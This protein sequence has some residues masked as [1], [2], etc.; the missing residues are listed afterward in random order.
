MKVGQRVGVRALYV[1]A[2]G[3]RA[4]SAYKMSRLKSD[5]GF[6]S[7]NR[8]PGISGYMFPRCRL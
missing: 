1:V 6:R 4:E 8:R 5:L 2:M 3:M 7:G